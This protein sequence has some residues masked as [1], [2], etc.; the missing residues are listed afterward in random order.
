MAPLLIPLWVSGLLVTLPAFVS[1][2][3]H[4]PAGLS[5][6]VKPSGTDRGSRRRR[7]GFELVMTGPSPRSARLT[8]PRSGRPRPRCRGAPADDPHQD[9]R[10]LWSRRPARQPAAPIEDYQRHLS[11]GASHLGLVLGVAVDL[12]PRPS[13]IGGG[14]RYRA[15][16]VAE[17]SVGTTLGASGRTAAA[18]YASLV[19]WSGA[20]GEGGRDSGER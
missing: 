7:S 8:P 2:S 1:P 12:A 14:G 15:D 20:L 5:H 16:D 4:F 17:A 18:W 6:V 3:W 11:S 13:R 10:S 19:F 9:C